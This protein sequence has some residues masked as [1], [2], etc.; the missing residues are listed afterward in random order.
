[1]PFIDRLD[2][3]RSVSVVGMEK[4][5]GKTECLNYVLRGLQGA[6]KRTVAVTSI[7]MDGEDVDQLYGNRKPEITLEAGT[8]FGTSEKHFR[9]R[10]IEAEVLDVTDINTSLGYVVTARALRRGNVIL[11]GPVMTTEMRRW[12]G[13]VSRFGVDITL[14]DG[15]LSRL[16]SASPAVCDGIILSTGAAYSINIPEL[17]RA[18]AFQVEMIRL[19]LCTHEGADCTVDSFI[20]GLP[21]NIDSMLSVELSGALTDK[22]VLSMPAGKEVIIPDFTRAFVTEQV[23]RDFIHRGGSIT[24]R[25]RSELIAV[26][27]NPVAPNGYSVDS[28]RLCAALSERLGMPVY[29]VFEETNKNERQ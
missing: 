1:M 28:G 6:G 18:T 10:R 12:I 26:C 21:E 19:P 11:S 2:S 27:A 29:D 15:A 24:V 7:G 22:A 20:G 23:Y 16:S 14:L 3:F 17:C 8:I 5:T 13:S 9:Q 4:N 25:R